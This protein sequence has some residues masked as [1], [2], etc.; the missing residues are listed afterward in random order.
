MSDKNNS[1]IA[2][3]N[4]KIN[5]FI[6][7]SSKDKVLVDTFVDKILIC[8]MG[9]HHNDIFCTSIEGLGI[10][11]GADWREEIKSHLAETQVVILMITPNYKE[12]EMCLNEMGAAWA[13]ESKVIPIVVP[14]FNFD[15]IGI[16]YQIKQ[17]LSLTDSSNLDQLK[18]E[19][20]SIFFNNV[21]TPRWNLKKLEAIRFFEDYVKK[22]PFSLPINRETVD[23]LENENLQLK[24]ALKELFDEK[25]KLSDYCIELETLKDKKAIQNLKIKSGLHDEVEYI[26]E[27]ATELGDLINS[28]SLIVQTSIF[29]DFTLKDINISP[30]IIRQYR[31]LVD[32][33][34]A[35]DLIDEECRIRYE[36]P[37]IIKVKKL[38]EELGDL[39]MKLPEKSYSILQKEFPDVQLSVY[40]LD[41]W[42]NVMGVKRI[43]F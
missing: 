29:I 22:N 5:I 11:T 24:E 25:E 33:A 26:I 30:D 40:N 14:P 36:H 10:K 31:S 34:Y 42:T 19:F 21:S 7:H 17:A 2:N 32:E 39:L 41:F 43:T 18:D 27:K 8:G 35:R 37:F 15:N 3:S 6:S 13:L 4:K 12:S 20:D 23:K 16:L 1:L 9:F 38:W 28:K